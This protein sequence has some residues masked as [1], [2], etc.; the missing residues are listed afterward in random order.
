MF[1][2]KIVDKLL[3]HWICFAHQP[4]EPPDA[5]T[6][7]GSSPQ[8]EDLSPAMAH[9]TVSNVAHKRVSVPRVY[10]PGTRT[11]LLTEARKMPCPSWSLPARVTCPFSLHTPGAICEFCY[12]DKGSYTRYP[13]VKR[14]QFVRLE[15]A[16]KCMRTAE[17]REEFKSVMTDA[18]TRT[19]LSYFRVHD[20]G[21]LFNPVYTRTWGEIVRAL[22]NIVFWFPTRAH[23][24]LLNIGSA[25]ADIWREALDF[26][27]SAKNAVVRPSA[28][29]FGDPAPVV[30]GFSAGSTA[31]V[32]GYSCPASKQGNACLDCRMCWDAPATPISYR[33]H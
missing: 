22:P 4:T 26:L 18:I 21:D 28:D 33:K 31:S 10:V 30:A 2:P 8:R 19:G 7:G 23:R 9:A 32:E 29:N 1:W 12:A 5:P 14:A 16:K 24:A 25:M 15:W 20:S 27:T 6:P 3:I 11:M 17:G 13:N